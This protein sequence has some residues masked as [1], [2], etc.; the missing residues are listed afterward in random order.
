MLPEKQDDAFNDFYKSARFN[1]I[2]DP[3]TTLLLHLATA[4]S[5]AIR[6]QRLCPGYILTVDRLAATPGFH[7]WSPVRA[8]PAVAESR[9]PDGLSRVSTPCN[10]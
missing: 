5:V 6:G 10:V 7:G 2:L 4:M 8:R 3:K 1:K 9:W